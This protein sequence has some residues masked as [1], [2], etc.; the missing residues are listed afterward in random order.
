M[1]EKDL[2]NQWAKSAKRLFESYGYGCVDDFTECLGDK[3]PSDLNSI[4]WKNLNS[5][6]YE[7][8]LAFIIKYFNDRKNI[9]ITDD[10]N[11]LLEDI[12]TKLFK[13]GFSRRDVTNFMDERHYD[14]RESYD[15]DTGLTDYELAEQHMTELAVDE[16]IKQFE[17]ACRKTN[18]FKSIL[19]KDFKYMQL[20]YSTQTLPFDIEI[21]TPELFDDIET[22]EEI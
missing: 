3:I 12:D 10:L 13:M 2:I 14:D 5:F 7:K 8:K 20:I 15:D 18:N 1:A 11:I 6:V 21:I 19:K 17:K 9:R 16:F 22:Y 4:M